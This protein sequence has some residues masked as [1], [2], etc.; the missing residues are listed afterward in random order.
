MGNTL[1]TYKY[2][3]LLLIAMQ[4]TSY[5]DK[6]KKKQLY[7]NKSEVLCTLHNEV[8]HAIKNKLKK[9]KQQHRMNYFWIYPTGLYFVKELKCMMD[10]Y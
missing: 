3:A 9:K 6:K 8:K 4:K 5:Q 10:V 2:Y 7:C 1:T